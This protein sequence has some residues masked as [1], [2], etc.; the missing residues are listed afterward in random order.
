MENSD[1]NRFVEIGRIGKARGLEG[2]ARFMPNENFTADLFDE[3]SLFYMRNRRG[4]FVPTR[5]EEFK[6]ESKR[7]RQSFFVKFDSIASRKDADDAMNRA[8]FAEKSD[9]KEVAVPENKGHDLTGY[10]VHHDGK[11]IGT[12][13]E[14]LDNPAHPIL[15]ISYKPGSLLIPF[16]VEFVAGVDHENAV[17]NCINIDQL[18]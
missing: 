4:D 8:V 12:V 7:S 14:V 2:H 17:I 16:V 6:A 11:E 13:L 15:E 5:L 1:N 18:I 10:H 3:A 9:L